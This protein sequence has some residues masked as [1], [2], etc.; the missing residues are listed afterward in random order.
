LTENFN[1]MDLVKLLE[2]NQKLHI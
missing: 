1:S 2:K